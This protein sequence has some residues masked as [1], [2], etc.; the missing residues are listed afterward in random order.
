MEGAVGVEP[1]NKGFADPP[2]T[3]ED[4]AHINEYNLEQFFV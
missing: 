1:T 4:H 3:D 2:S